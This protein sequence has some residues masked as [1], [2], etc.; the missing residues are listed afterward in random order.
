[1]AVRLRRRLRPAGAGRSVPFATDP[2]RQNGG[3]PYPVEGLRWPTTTATTTYNILIGS[4]RT[5]P[6]RRTDYFVIC[7]S[8][9]S[10]APACRRPTTFQ[11]TTTTLARRPQR[12]WWRVVSAAAISASTHPTTIRSG[13]LARGR[14]PTLESSRT[15]PGRLRCRHRRGGVPESVPGT[16]ARGASVGAIAAL[17]STVIRRCSPDRLRHARG[18]R[19]CS[20][21]S[22]TQLHLGASGTDNVFGHGR[23]DALAAATAGW[24]V[25]NAD[26]HGLTRRP[27]LRH[28]RRRRPQPLRHLHTDRNGHNQSD[29]RHDGGGCRM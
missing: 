15:S 2:Q 25:R 11:R 1:M 13:M 9:F 10:L 6:R 18:M 27:R 8:C 23:I 16:S 24:P 4:T 17:I 21:R 22:S 28:I 7:R 12:R 19:R 3:F 5:S 14:Q 26:E 29:A 20:M